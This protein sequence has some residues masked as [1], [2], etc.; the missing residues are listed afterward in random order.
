[1]TKNE[2]ISST[3]KETK[4]RRKT[5][6]CKV[7]ELKID[8]SHLNNDTKEH[9]KM[10]FLESKWFYNYI[11]SQDIFS[12]DYKTSKVSI[13]VKDEFQEREIKHL[14]S[15]M[16]QAILQKIQDS[17][18][19]LSK[20]KNNGNKIGSLK[21]KSKFTTIPLKQYNNTY[22]ILNNKYIKIQGI[23]QKVR[24]NGLNQIPE[25]SEFANAVLI[26]KSNEYYIKITCFIPKT[27]SVNDSAIGID[28]GLASQLTLSNGI[29]IQYRIP[30]S[31]QI[32]KTYQRISKKQNKSKNKEKIKIKLEKQFEH[33]NNIKKD[34]RNKTISILKKQ[35]GIICFQ[36]ENVKS[37]QRLWGSKI[38]DTSIGG[39][40]STLKMRVH[41]PIEVNRLFPST[42]TCS[43]CNNKQEI[44]LSERVYVCNHCNS[45][46]PRD[47]N[48]S[49]NILKEGLK[50][51]P[52]ERRNV[53]PVEIES[54][55]LIMLEY[56]NT[57][58]Q[59]K[60]SLVYEAG[61]LTALA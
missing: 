38:L 51:L 61:S 25:N 17:I 15:Q 29:S 37:W 22:K 6:D 43:L 45:K 8:K 24:V 3:L 39:I 50:Q 44:A 12:F 41:T 23:K 58:P 4:E 10:L 36:D 26:N 55:T 48:S 53:K 49:K 9:L 2:Q 18:S 13:K 27:E 47:Y 52:T 11:I 32:R 5:Q 46:L 56:L 34:I 16:K 21:F 20:S 14:S 40:I 59:V 60:A 7:F 19:S 33:I 57:I 35:Y 30:V 28:F 54:S 42:K 31:K 1:M